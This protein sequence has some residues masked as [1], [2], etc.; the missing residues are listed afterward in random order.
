MCLMEFRD[1]LQKNTIT[2]TIIIMWGVF[3]LA[4]CMTILGLAIFDGVK[5]NNHMNVT[6]IISYCGVVAFSATLFAGVVLCSF[7]IYWRFEDPIREFLNLEIENYDNL[8]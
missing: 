2:N 6:S 7:N 4:I 5:R 8:P 1:E 3:T